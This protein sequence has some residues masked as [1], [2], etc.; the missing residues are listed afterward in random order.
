MY[1]VGRRL[2]NIKLSC[3]LFE[4]IQAVVDSTSAI[5]QA[6]FSRHILVSSS[7][8]S[9]SFFGAS[10]CWFFEVCDSYELLHLLILLIL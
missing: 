1:T 2:S 9:V 5:I 3:N 8:K 7:F 10:R 4:F 6:V